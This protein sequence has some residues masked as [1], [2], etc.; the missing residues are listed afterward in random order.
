MSELTAVVSDAAEIATATGDLDG[1][2][3]AGTVEN[4]A[5]AVVDGE[6]ARVGPSAAVTRE[7]PPENATQAIDAGG[8]E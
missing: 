2:D 3:P 7:F 6:V 4:G 5:V 1:D 8:R